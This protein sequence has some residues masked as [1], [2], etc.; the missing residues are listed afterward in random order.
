MGNLSSGVPTDQDG[1]DSIRRYYGDFSFESK[2]KVNE[3]IENIAK[4][5]KRGNTLI[6]RSAQQKNPHTSGD[7]FFPGAS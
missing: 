1:G 4:Y 3:M 7:A 6:P 2:N 5:P